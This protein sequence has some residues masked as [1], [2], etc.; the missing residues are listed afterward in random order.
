MPVVYGK[1]EG[2][3]NGIKTVIPNISEVALA[4]HRPPGEVNKFFGCEL[5]AQTSY[6]ADTDRA[7]VNGAHTDAVLM[8]LIHRYIEK[9][10]ICPQCGLPETDYKI[11]ADIIWHKCAACGAKEMV[12]MSHKLCTYILAQ[13]KK[14]KKDAASKNKGRDGKKTKSKDKEIESADDKTDRKEKKASYLLNINFAVVKLTYTTS[15]Q[16]KKEKKGKKEKKEKKEKKKK[17]DVEEDE[18]KS[19]EDELIGVDDANAMKLAVNSIQDFMKINPD[20]SVDEIV[21]LVVNQQMA[22]ALKSFDKIHI[23]TQAFLTKNFFSNDEIKKYGSIFEKVIN[24]NPIMERHLISALENLCISTPKNFPIM[25]KQFYD[26]DILEEDT[27]LEWAGEG[28]T[29]FTLDSVDEDSRAILRGEAE[30]V[31]T[32]LQEADTDS[33]DE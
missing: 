32:W 21:E 29:E 4:L 13:N 28:R 10:V 24:E 5:G 14:Q 26:A 19:S 11:K 3:G 27:I 31:I 6:S 7:V 8:N 1:I 23:I 30:P 25:I 18:D 17:A 16:D 9:F 12:D 20:A 15:S 33:D 2:R 22:S